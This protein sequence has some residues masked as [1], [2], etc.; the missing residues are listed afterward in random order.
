MEIAADEAKGVLEM[1]VGAALTAYGFG[2]V[3]KGLRNP[4]DRRGFL[5]VAGVG[6]ALGAAAIGLGLPEVM[7]ARSIKSL[8]RAFDGGDGLIAEQDVAYDDPRRRALADN[9]ILNN[10][11][12]SGMRNVVNAIKLNSLAEHMKGN[13]GRKPTLYLVYG[14]SH[15]GIADLLA[16]EGKMEAGARR[17]QRQIREFLEPEWV[18]KVTQWRYDDKVE[19]HWEVR[20]LK[21]PQLNPR[22]DESDKKKAPPLERMEPPKPPQKE[23]P[24]KRVLARREFLERVSGR[25]S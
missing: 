16:D 14:M 8:N 10:S 2:R 20:R 22:A 5:A 9:D 4:T 6:V 11:M 21:V 18:D 19:W 12:T 24:H 3:R 25:G 1:G 15:T 13:L 17:W 7:N 23:D